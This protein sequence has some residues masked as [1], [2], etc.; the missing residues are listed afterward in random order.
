MNLDET[1]DI[2][3]ASRLNHTDLGA[4][5]YAISKGDESIDHGIG[6]ENASPQRQRQ[7]AQILDNGKR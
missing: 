5:E 2:H 6:M 1:K 3:D 4:G 7:G